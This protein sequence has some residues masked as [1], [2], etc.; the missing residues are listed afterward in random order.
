MDALVA[1]RAFMKSQGLD[2]F[3]VFDTDEYLNEYIPLEENPRYYITGFTGSTGVALVTMEEAFLFVD[4]RYHLQADNEV[5]PDY[6]T[7]VKMGMDNA[8]EHTLSGRLSQ[9][10]ASGER[11]GFVSTK[12]S[13][14]QFKKLQEKAPTA[15]FVPFDFDPVLDSVELAPT[16]CKN[17]VR[18]VLTNVS[19]KSAADKLTAV[20]NEMK[21][22]GI[23]VM[24]VSKLDELAYLTNLR[25]D[26]IP[27]SSSFKAKLVVGSSQAFVFCDI[28]CVPDDIPEKLGRRFVFMESYEFEDF[29]KGIDVNKR[30]GLCP[31]TC[32]YYIY[33]S[34]K[35]EVIE[36]CSSPISEMKSIKNLSEIEHMKDCFARTDRAV[37]NSQKWLADSLKYFKNISE[38]AFS[39]KVKELY[40]E[41]GALD[42]S[43]EVLAASGTNSAIIHYTSPSNEKIIKRSDIVLLDSGAYFEGGYATDMTRTFL[44]SGD[45]RD[46]STEQKQLYTAVLKGFLAGLNYPVTKETTGFDIDARVREILEVNKPEGYSFSH[47][48]GHGVGINVHEDPPRISPSEAGKRPLK[49]GMCFTI[50]PGLYK[51]GAGGVRIENTVYLESTEEGLKIKSF[52]ACPLDTAL[53]EMSMLDEQEL[54][55]LDHCQRNAI[56]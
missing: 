31:D 44:A 21:A 48:T 12:L 5:N 38:K 2:C 27:F 22:Q 3:I 16:D 54:E 56:S 29:I 36:V 11:V 13:V 19:G 1:L 55:W 7:V 46:A 53:I 28:D 51:S 15:E 9:L 35:N 37:L 4:G 14:S 24:V 17:P 39:D 32:N 52:A 43:F 30:V 45:T 18:S 47:G 20:E 42:L 34:I 6:I 25:G 33:S 10:A 26:S 49:P 50:E 8:V 23:D 40:K 41:Q